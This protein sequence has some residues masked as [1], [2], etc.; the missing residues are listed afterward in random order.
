MIFILLFKLIPCPIHWMVYLLA[1]M[2]FILEF[3][4][5]FSSAQNGPLC[6]DPWKY[7]FH[8]NCLEHYICISLRLRQKNV[9]NFVGFLE[10]GRTW[11]FVFNFYW[12][13]STREPQLVTISLSK[14]RM[15]KIRLNFTSITVI[16]EHWHR[17]VQ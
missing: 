7:K 16:A 1:Y 11:Y 5:S 6:P 4:S 13:L 8:L 12:P 14:L 17:W 9:Q 3:Q 10:D 15:L 2:N